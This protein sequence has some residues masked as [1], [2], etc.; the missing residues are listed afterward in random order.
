MW[1]H[2]LRE[3][4]F[5]GCF[6]F[7]LSAMV[8]CN[9][10]DRSIKTTPTFDGKLELLARPSANFTI[11]EFTDDMKVPQ[12]K[13]T[14]LPGYW[15]L[16]SGLLEQYGCDYTVHQGRQRGSSLEARGETSRKQRVDPTAALR[17]CPILRVNAM[18]GLAPMYAP[19]I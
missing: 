8:S 15:D 5:K 18:V 2:L 11:Y 16:R 4:L 17:P 9:Q 12:P 1:K 7:I 3:Y 10:S 14:N 13:W 6:L 19:G